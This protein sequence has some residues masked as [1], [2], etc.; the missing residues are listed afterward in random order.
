MSQVA[1]QLLQAVKGM[2]PHLVASVLSEL[3]SD[4]QMAQRIGLDAEI[5]EILHML[6]GPTGAQDRSEDIDDEEKFLYGDAEDP[7]LPSEPVRPQGLDLYG[8]VTEDALYDDY[9][10]SQ[11]P[12]LPQ[13][14]GL[15]PGPHLHA[16][17]AMG[18]VDERYRASVSPDQNLTGPEPPG[19]G[20]RQALDEYEKIQDLLKTIGMDLGVTEISKMAART[21]ERLHG[22]KP[23]KT[24]TRRQRSSSG[25]SQGGR[26]RRRR[27]HSRRRSHSSSSSGESWSSDDGRR[28]RSIP[29]KS[30]KH[31]KESSAEKT[32][33]T[34]PPNIEPPLKTPDAPP[35]HPGA[36]SYPPTQVHGIM[37]PNFP[38]PGFG[39]YGN[40][41]PY[42]PGQWPPMYPPPNMAIPPNTSPEE[43]P[44]S[45]P[46]P[47][48]YST[49][50]DHQGAQGGSS[51]KE[52]LR[53]I[54]HV[55]FLLRRLHFGLFTSSL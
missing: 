48:P 19:P 37:P 47:N 41:L 1:D 51:S 5:K 13:T 16:P 25:S 14:F 15:P 43:F 38:P 28:K 53:S 18:Q 12:A 7:K 45:L 17:R 44:S 27:G 23:P 21:K 39:Q 40:Y 29:A 22:N 24:P 20:E 6:G 2:E 34:A 4:P 46:Y 26:A 32:T 55:Y 50:P 3:Q 54:Q 52:S 49:P 9:P 36:P 10:P 30:H 42:M 33:A 35:P 31:S 8:D 11:E